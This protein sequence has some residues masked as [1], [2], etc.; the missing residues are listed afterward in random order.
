[1]SRYNARALR[2]VDSRKLRG[3]RDERC[4]APSQMERSISACIGTRP[5][6]LD[7]GGVSPALALNFLG[8][9]VAVEKNLLCPGNSNIIA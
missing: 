8:G 5:F 4:L 9:V 1:M 3:P 7:G 2:L 6:D